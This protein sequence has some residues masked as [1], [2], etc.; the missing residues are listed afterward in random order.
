[1]INPTPK[2]NNGV[3]RGNALSHSRPNKSAGAIARTLPGSSSR[4]NADFYVCGFPCQPFSG[5]G[6]KEGVEDPRGSGRNPPL[7]APCSP[8]G[9]LDLFLIPLLLSILPPP[10]HYPSPPPSFTPL[11]SYPSIPPTP[12]P[13][14]LLLLLTPLLL[15]PPSSSTAGLL[16]NS[17]WQ[18]GRLFSPFSPFPCVCVWSDVKNPPPPPRPPPY[19]SPP[20]YIWFLLFLLLIPLLSPHPRHPLHLPF[21]PSP[22][23][24]APHRPSAAG[25]RGILVFHNLNYIM[26]KK[27]K[28]F[29]LET[30]R[31]RGGGGCL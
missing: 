28:C 13:S 16:D 24:A 20:P 1:M 9:V 17:V 19:P 27:P 30:R 23:P 8:R 11:P 22:L 12:F 31:A 5:L 4:A 18:L 15:P 25:G 26:V 6:L 21:S 29:V 7:P 10:P 2:G 14:L 3:G